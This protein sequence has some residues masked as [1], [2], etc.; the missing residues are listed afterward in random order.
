LLQNRPDVKQV[1]YEL[2]ASKCDLD[3][4]Q[5]AFLPN[6]VLGGSIGYQAFRLPLVFNSPESLVYQFVGNVTAPLWNKS[7]IKSYFAIA[8]AEQINA[9]LKYQKSIV[10]A[11]QEVD[12]EANYMVNLEE[13][14]KTKK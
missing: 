5:K 4:A 3:A 11:F 10:M 8:K 14:F 1:E 12:T 6:F 7:A 9:Y 2:L 13:M